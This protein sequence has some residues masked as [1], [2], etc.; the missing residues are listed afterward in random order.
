MSRRAEA[1][2]HLVETIATALATAY[3]GGSDSL[4]EVAKFLIIERTGQVQDL[5]DALRDYK[6][7]L[8]IEER[9]RERREVQA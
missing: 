7:E 1:E 5:K 3:S 8:Y 4:E 2:Q 9:A 6:F